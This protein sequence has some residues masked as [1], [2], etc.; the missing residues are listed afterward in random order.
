MTLGEFYI[1][2]PQGILIFLLTLTW[3]AKMS[4]HGKDRSP[5]NGWAGTV[6][7]MLWG[8]LLYWGGFFQVRP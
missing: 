5:Y 3:W 1:G 6:D 8:I 7:F 4:L 2:W